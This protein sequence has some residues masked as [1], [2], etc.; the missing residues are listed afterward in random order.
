LDIAV[1]DDMLEPVAKRTVR[2]LEENVQNGT[3][4][5]GPRI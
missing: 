1:L 5:V 4:A 3:E 2:V